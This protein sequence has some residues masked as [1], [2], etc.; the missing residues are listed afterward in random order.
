MNYHGYLHHTPT[1]VTACEVELLPL[2]VLVWYNEA[3]CS[4]PDIL[5]RRARK[6][7]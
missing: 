3:T 5:N 4:G 1:L 7:Y 6:W 2:Y